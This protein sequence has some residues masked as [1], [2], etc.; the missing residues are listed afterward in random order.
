M[1]PKSPSGKPSPV[2]FAPHR[3]RDQFLQSLA[4]FERGETNERVLDDDVDVD[5][6]VDK[7]FGNITIPPT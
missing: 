6:F 4:L 1:Q 3:D 5:A 2:K 7:A